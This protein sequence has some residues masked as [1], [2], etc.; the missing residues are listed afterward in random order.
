MTTDKNDKYGPPQEPRGYK[1]AA[2]N[3]LESKN[4]DE[5]MTR[6]RNELAKR[7]VESLET[8]E[9]ARLAKSDLQSVKVLY[10]YWLQSGVRR[11]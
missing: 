11:L 5:F 3:L 4:A 6:F 2:L 10:E 7:K 9:A 8:D 1:H